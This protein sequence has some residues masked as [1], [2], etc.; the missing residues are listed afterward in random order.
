MDDDDDDDDD[1]DDDD[2]DDD[3]DDDDDD[4]D[5]DVHLYSPHINA[6]SIL[7]AQGFVVFLAR[8]NLWL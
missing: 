3:Y 4:D 2:D 6:G 5:N 1:G 8:E 7:R